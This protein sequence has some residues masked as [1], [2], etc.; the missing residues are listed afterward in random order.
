MAVHEPAF[1]D[2]LELLLLCMH[3]DDIRIAAL[4]DLDGSAGSDGYHIDLDAGLLLK[5]RQNIIEQ[6]RVLRA[7]GRRAT[8]AGFA[9]KPQC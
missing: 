1:L 4:A 8:D 9:Q 5:D 3:E 7:R 6:A 2:S